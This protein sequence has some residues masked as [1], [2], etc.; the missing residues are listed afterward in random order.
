[1]K[2]LHIN[3]ID[4][5]GAAIAAIRLHYLLLDNMQ[6]S[7]IL[8]LYRSGNT[9]IKEAYYFE[10]LFRTQFIFK[11][12]VNLNIIYNRR[13]TFYKKKV[14][15]NGL[16]SLFNISKHPL[17]IWADVI[18]LHWVVKF[19]DW[20]KVFSH[21]DKKYVWTCHDM[22]PFT[23]GNHYETGYKN[24]FAAIANYNLK[25]K[26]SIIKNVNITLIGPSQW[27]A[28]LLQK[29]TVFGSKPVF[30]VKNPINHNIFNTIEVNDYKKKLNISTSKKVILFVAENPND[31]RKGFAL[32]TNALTKINNKDNYHLLIIGAK[33]DF[34]CDISF[35]QTGVINDQETL[36]KIYNI[37]DCFVM[38]SIED[39]LPNTVSEALLCGTPVV[40]FN[41]GGIPEMVIDDK[42]GL[43]CKEIDQLNQSIEAILTI[44]KNAITIRDNALIQLDNRKL[45]DKFRNIYTT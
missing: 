12:L 3:T 26:I 45:Y 25:Q 6:D 30:T 44:K 10:D 31:E 7:K 20:E 43:I 22:N 36:S 19:L 24:E 8:F 27:I 5:G 35:T 17:F 15:F 41:I 40:G 28:N 18:H 37:S 14:Y 33:F 34:N 32:L 39:N 2:I 9:N 13:F 29:S 1:L 16:Q 38:P 42:T 21:I 23:G 11:F 4:S